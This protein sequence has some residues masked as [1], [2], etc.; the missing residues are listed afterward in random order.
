MKYS[1]LKNSALILVVLSVTNPL[2]GSYV[3]AEDAFYDDIQVVKVG[4]PAKSADGEDKAALKEAKA[5]AKE[6][7]RAAKQEVKV[8][9]KAAKEKAQAEAKAK[10][11][12]ESARK[13]EEKRVKK[14]EQ[15]PLQEPIQPASKVLGAYED[16]NLVPL[17]DFLASL[18]Y[19]WTSNQWKT[20]Y[21]IYLPR[22][23]LS[24]GIIHMDANGLTEP[25]ALNYVK[26]SSI[27]KDINGNETKSTKEANFVDTTAFKLLVDGMP[28]P[29]ARI[30]KNPV[31]WAFDPLTTEANPS[32]MH[33]GGTNIMSPSWFVLQS[34]GLKASPRISTDYVRTYRDKGYQVW[35]LVTNQFDPSFTAS[36]LGQSG[37]GLWATYAQ[38]LVQYALAYGFEGYNFDFENIH[39]SHRDQLSHFVAYLSDYLHQYGIYTS[40]DVTGYSTSEYW[41][42][43]YDRPALS[44]SVDYVVHMAYDEV[45]HSSPTA[46]P[47]ASYPWVRKQ[48]EQMLG[49]VPA[50]KLVL[51]IPFYTRIWT[52]SYGRAQSKTLTIA[53]SRNYLKAF[54][55]HVV[56]NDQLKGYTLTI[57][58]QGLVKK[59]PRI[60][61]ILNHQS[62]T[63]QKIWF[64]DNKSLEEKLALVNELQLAGFAAWR[65]G[66]EDK[67]INDMIYQYPLYKAVDQVKAID[68]SKPL[69]QAKESHQAKTD[70]LAK[71]SNKANV[72][73]RTKAL[74]HAKIVDTKG[75]NDASLKKDK[76]SKTIQE[77][78]SQSK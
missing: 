73:N 8:Q 69:D 35:P 63:V 39:E 71:V 12:E 36:I 64:E 14:L 4:D 62:G 21:T 38:Q 17:N 46:G 51:G 18:P 32:L 65:K 50:N 49:E 72:S 47:V 78:I 43:V 67:D 61:L 5:R 23:N 1:K 56:W 76:D 42:R 10:K 40:I 54:E 68:Q 3:G 53:D 77:E 25:L 6:E 15:A 48:T 59:D 2:W 24:D 29:K 33:E 31:A 16:E 66:F 22:V 7:E 13:K 70:D 19:K 60:P 28:L 27:I 58:S 52:E 20:Q 75:K 26:R 9:E 11:E 34:N 41:S 57:P 55:D 45:G 74:D 30:L 37:S 44:K